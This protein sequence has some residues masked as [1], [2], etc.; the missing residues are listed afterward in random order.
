MH[1]HTIEN[2][3]NNERL[4][5]PENTRKQYVICCDRREI[6]P[7]SSEAEVNEPSR[8]STLGREQTSTTK[9]SKVNTNQIYGFTRLRIDC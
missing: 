2:K 3:W 5:A 1:S 8:I 7:K 9:I 4:E 6:F